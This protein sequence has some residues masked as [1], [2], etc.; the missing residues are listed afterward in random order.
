RQK[1]TTHKTDNVVI[2]LFFFFF[3][4]SRRRHTR[5]PRDWSSDV[6]SSDLFPGRFGGLR[7][8]VR[9]DLHAVVFV[10]LRRKNER[11]EFFLLQAA[12]EIQ[13]ILFSRE[14]SHLEDE[15]A[16]GNEGRVLSFRRTAGAPLLNGGFRSRCQ[17]IFCRRS[18]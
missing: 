12:R 7:I 3:F 18:G 16:S 9:A 1:S 14:G 5:W 13:G 17:V 4:S 11:G 2:V 10:A 8:S 6:C 15:C